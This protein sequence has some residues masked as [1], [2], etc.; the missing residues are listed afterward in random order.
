MTVYDLVF[1]GILLFSV[2]SGLLRGGT[3]EIVGTASFILAVLIAIWLSPW[4]RETFNLD[5]M[6]S[7]I[8]L[9]IVFIL[10]Y[11]GIR[12]M[13]NAVA[14]K[15]NKQSVL[16]YADRILGVGFGVARALV[17]LGFIHLLFSVVLPKDKPEWFTDAKTYP[18]SVQCAKTIL[19]VA[20]SWAHYADQ[21]ASGKK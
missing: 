3:R 21:V 6:V 8:A 7:L 14:E 5:E 11:F 1:L 10:T 4:L 15:V 17:F 12:L 2:L 20:P 18:L 19:S 16:S 13:G 9:V